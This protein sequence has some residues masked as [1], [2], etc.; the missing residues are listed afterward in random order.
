MKISI[1]YGSP[2]PKGRLYKLLDEIQRQFDESC[3]ITVVRVDPTQTEDSVVAAWSQAEVDVISEADAVVVSSPVFRGTLTGTM[4]TLFDLLSVEHLRNKPV[5]IVTMAAAPHHF[6]SAERHIRDILS[7]FG[8]LVAPNSLFFVDNDFSR[9]IH[10]EE[11]QL[12]IKQFSEQLTTLHKKLGR[13]EFGPTPLT[14][15]F[16]QKKQMEN[17]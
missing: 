1:I 13:E 10:T 16:S 15:K 2:T 3:E 6:L 8:A 12:D 5:G 11:V 7:W 4:K 9:N 14:I 17:K